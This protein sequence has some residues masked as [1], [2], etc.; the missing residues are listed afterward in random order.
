MSQ[1]AVGSLEHTIRSRHS[2][3][4]F[5]PRPVPRNLLD[6]AL[7]LAQHSPSNSNTQPWRLFIAS[8][9]ARDR[10]AA[11]LLDAVGKAVPNIPPLPEKFRHYRSALGLQV[12]GEGMGIAHE[13]KEG[14]AA[15]V[16]KNFEFFGAPT[17]GIVCMDRELGFA[18]AL[19][20]GLYLQT[21][22]LALT[23]RGLDTCVEVSVAGYP[24]VLRRELGI[25]EELHVICGLAVGYAD[26]EFHANQLHSSRDAV[27][28]SVRFIE[29]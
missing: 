16:L 29:S 26:N 1:P 9:A 11:A 5:L 24:E 6:E 4:K 25:A 3:R 28:Q 18:D 21:L 23:E 8:G 27:E 12:Y 22:M 17:V 19:S 7:G 15:A 20:V 10:L 14:R 13:D 2:T